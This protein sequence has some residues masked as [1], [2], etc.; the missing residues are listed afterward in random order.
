METNLKIVNRKGTL[1][2]KL[3]NVYILL[4]E[5]GKLVI[6]KVIISKLLLNEHESVNMKMNTIRKQ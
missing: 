6:N 5:S 4:M 1:N 2:G 3:K